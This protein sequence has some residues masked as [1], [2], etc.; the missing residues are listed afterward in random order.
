MNNEELS[1]KIAAALGVILCVFIA[2]MLGIFVI[3][4]YRWALGQ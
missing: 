1:N 2:A 3:I 4:G